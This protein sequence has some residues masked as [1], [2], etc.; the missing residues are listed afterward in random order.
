VCDSLCAQNGGLNPDF[1]GSCAPLSCD[2]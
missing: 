2:V 1:S